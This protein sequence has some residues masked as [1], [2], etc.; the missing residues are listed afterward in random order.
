MEYTIRQTVIED[1]PGILELV[2]EFHDESL[3][4]LGVVCDDAVAK[5]LMPKMIKTS[6][7]LEI[8]GKIVGVIAGFVTSHIVSKE[9]LMQETIWFVA[10]E[11]RKHGI[12]LYRGFENMCRVMG[13]KH[14]VMGNMSGKRDEVFERFYLKRGFKLSEVQYIKRLEEGDETTL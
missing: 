6:I 9:P 5:E 10:K 3:N 11:H 13:M 8:E 12:K 7:V 14:L 4:D 2:H 1:L